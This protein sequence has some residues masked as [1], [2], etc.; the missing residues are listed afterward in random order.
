MAHFICG[1]FLPRRWRLL[2]HLYYPLLTY[3]YYYKGGRGG[4]HA[5]RMVGFR[6]GSQKFSICVANIRLMNGWMECR[7][8]RL[9]RYLCLLCV[10][11]CSLCVWSDTPYTPCNHAAVQLT[12]LYARSRLESIQRRTNSACLLLLWAW[13]SADTIEVVCL[14]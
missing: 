13:G 7:W 2:A 3:Y 9:S 5:Q 11:V 12:Y 14:C 1:S 4:G 10:C 8:S 6:S